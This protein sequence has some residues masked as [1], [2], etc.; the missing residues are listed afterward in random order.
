MSEKT[1]KNSQDNGT[2]KKRS[3]ASRGKRFSRAQKEEILEYAASHS[4]REAEQKYS[5]TFSSIYEWRRA[6]ERRGHLENKI[7]DKEVVNGSDSKEE[8]KNRVLSMWKRHPGYGPSQIRNMLHREGYKISVGTVRHIMEENGYI[9]PTLKR[10][11]HV[12]RYEANR[13]LELYH[14]DFYHFYVH[15]QKQCLLFIQDD[16]SRFIVGWTL[17]SSEQADP[18]IAATESTI[19]R[20][21]CPKGIMT[22]RG[23][24]FHS[25]KGLSRFE[26]LLE[27]YEINH[28]LAKEPAVNGKVE[29]LNA[30]F[31]KECLT[32]NEFMDLGDALRVIGRWVDHYNH[33]RTHHSLGGLLVP[34]DRFYG[35]AEQTL[36]RIEQGLGAKT[37]DLTAVEQRW[38]TLFS[39]R[40]KAGKPE[41]WLMGKKIW[42]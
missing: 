21:G 13:P 10:R 35:I 37:D 12:G 33:R 26:A 15:K 39:I 5:V 3:Y 19:E 16:F 24:A 18:V 14:Y 40:T 23:S 38:V 29:A 2:K 8:R 28:F 11:E 32:V 30:A 1:E 17:A 22:D 6:L 34:A 36:K 4:V 31:Q 41:I 20:Y 42:E 27:E 9:P 25:W 7:P